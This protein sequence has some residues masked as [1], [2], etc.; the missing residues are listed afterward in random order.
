MDGDGFFFFFEIEKVPVK[1]I[2]LGRAQFNVSQF[3]DFLVRCMTKLTSLKSVFFNRT[4][5]NTNR[6]IAELNRT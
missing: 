6:S 3:I 5:S 4:Q 2:N 1:L